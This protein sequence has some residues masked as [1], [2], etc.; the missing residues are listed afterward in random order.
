M[1]PAI[2]RLRAEVQSDRVAVARWLDELADLELDSDS[3]RGTLAQAAW[4]L[5]HAYSGIEAILERTMRTI[6]GSLPEGPDFHKELL[7]AS[8]LAIGGIRKPLLS[9]RTVV[10]LH[11]LRGFRHFV[12]HAYAVKL[13]PDRLA[14]LQRRTAAL[15]GDLDDDLDALDDWL[16]E[17]ASAVD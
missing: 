4:C 7:D 10:A 15:R 3:D 12:R 9:E 1:K 13:E 11:D 17:L 5:H 6:E 14:D 8:A 16:Q 2:E